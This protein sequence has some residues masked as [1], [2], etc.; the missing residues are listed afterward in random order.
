MSKSLF[1]GLSRYLPG[2]G[3]INTYKKEWLS[4]DIAAGL[5]VAAIAIPVSIAYA[6]IAGLPPEVGLYSSVL[7]MIAYA[8]FGSSRQL[9]VGPDSA[10]CILIASAL[11]PVAAFGSELYQSYSVILALITGVLCILGGVL[12]FG[13]IANF[14]SKPILTGYLNGL[15]ISIIAGQLGKF[16]GFSLDSAGFFRMM[17][18]F[19]SKINDTHILTFAV[20]ISAFIF[21]R[22]FKKYFK[23]IPAPLIAVII[24]IIVVTVIGMENSGLK[25]VGHVP[26]GFPVIT[27]PDV[28]LSELGILISHSFGIVLISYCSAMLTNKSFAVKNGYSIDANKD[29]IALGVANIFSGLSQGFVISGADSRTAVNDSSGGK[30]QLVSVIAALSIAVV[31]MFLTQYLEYLPVAVLSAII[32][33][34]SIGLFNFEYLRK[35]YHVSRNEFFLA[36]ITSLSVITI[37]VIPAVLIAVGLS[38]LRL[39]AKASKPH[40]HILGKV[41]GLN[42]YHDINEFK[43]AVKIPGIMIYRFEAPLLF[44]NADYFKK[45]V[46]EFIDNERREINFLILDASPLIRIDITAAEIFED[47][48]FELKADNIVFGI[49]KLNSNVNLILKRANITEKIGEDNIFESVHSAVEYYSNKLK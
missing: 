31:I 10:T 33:S 38:L 44:F 13:F 49:A 2:L 26:A 12:K 30:T 41:E 7:P 15:A 4:K 9:M 8:L 6:G 17:I 27:I 22:I 45:R 3:L 29:F 25:V 14:L 32:I 18:D 21:L 24:S 47:L 34:A 42:S 1:S 37:G 43:D 11:I 16:F 40:D 36:V 5:S 23:R 39:L 28:G 46:Y 35:L 48:I 19:F 20:G